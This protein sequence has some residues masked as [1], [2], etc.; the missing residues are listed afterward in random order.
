MH[1][2]SGLLKSKAFIYGAALVIVI[3]G[4]ALFSTRNND[5]D[6]EVLVVE[7]GDFIQEVSVSGK[8]IAAQEVDLSFPET[9]RV[10]SIAVKVG[11]KVARG[12]ALASLASENL[13]SQL[14][15]AE[16][17]LALKRAES[18][19]TTVNLD[20]VKREQDTLVQSAYRKLLSSDLSVVA[21]ENTYD[22]D[23]PVVTGSYKGK[24]GT[25]RIR[26]E[27][28]I[29][30]SDFELRTFNLETTGPTEILDNEP[31]PLGTQG[32][33]LTFP[34]AVSG[35]HD[36]TWEVYIPNT[37]SSSYLGNHSAYQ[38]AL[39]ARDVAISSAEA[40]LRDGP[41]GSVVGAE[42]QRAEAEVARIR[43]AIAERTIRAPF[44]GVV[45]VVDAKLGG[46]IGA[47]EPAVSLISAGTLQIESF[48]PEVNI[49]LIE[50][51]DIAEVTLDAYGTD[52]KFAATVVS[53]DPAETIR[54]G[55][56]TYRALL[57][58]EE[59]DER[60]RSGMTANV[61]IKTDERKD[62][63]SIPQGIVSDRDGK[64]YV[65]VKTGGEIEEREVTIGTV[66]SLGNVE[67]VSGLNEGE[68]VVLSE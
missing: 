64:K 13:V 25:Y 19:N 20:E 29:N 43:S 45:T 15:A 5:A 9:G 40:E 67:I 6:A 60:I 3:G 38:E 28:K 8:V 2:M 49:A 26:I 63:I 32:L 24:E 10:V 35:Y 16:A 65:R 4:I 50:V 48:V 39:R 17:D 57:Q 52:V 66:S 59:N 47:N 34:D 21:Q 7:R 18:R 27:R 31:T 22:V 42:L 51:E 46:T 11:D 62:V 33:F 54:D 23:P 12:Q 68:M 58:F 55:V 14:R 41:S 53:I 36:T 30:S 44:N 56:S 61:R 37:K 1:T